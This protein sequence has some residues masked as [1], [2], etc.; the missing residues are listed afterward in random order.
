LLVGVLCLA[1]PSPC[2]EGV[3]FG[4]RVALA[5]EPRDPHARQAKA[6]FEEGLALSDEGKWADALAAFQRSD[7]L[8]PSPTVRF[9]IAASLR[10]L[11]RYVAAKHVLQG[12]LE[13]ADAAGTQPAK[14]PIKPALRTEVAR[15]L[16]QVK[17]K[18]VAARLRADPADAAI[19]V[20]GAPLQVT[21]GGDAELD[22]GRHVFVIRA[23]G[24]ETTTVTKEVSRADATVTLT[25][26]PTV[27]PQAPATDP[28]YKRW[29]FWTVAGVVVAGAAATV[30]A[31]ELQ[32]RAAAAPPPP[33]TANLIIPAA[34]HF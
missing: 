34:L 28:V 18:I 8:V 33:N 23:P 17:E 25:A 26:A 24:H 19:E 31:I 30:V 2:P 5:A 20:D 11:G 22:P 14:A 9:N 15:L 7:A 13:D 32:P 12:I 10:A 6:A 21:T 3:A 1:S 4:G 29:W 27:A 16:D